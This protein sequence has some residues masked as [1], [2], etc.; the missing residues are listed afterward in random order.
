MGRRN[1]TIPST[2]TVNVDEDVWSI[3]SFV[4]YHKDF[5]F[6][7]TWQSKNYEMRYFLQ[8]QTMPYL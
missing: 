1:P 4:Q 5:A 8:V 6:D 3:I 7:L 2:V